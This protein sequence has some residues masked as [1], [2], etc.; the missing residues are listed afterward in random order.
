MRRKGLAATVDILVFTMGRNGSEILLIERKYKPFQGNW[1][2]PGG[3]V[4]ENETFLQAAQREL[5]EETMIANLALNHLGVFD[6]PDRDPRGRTVSVAFWT[7][8]VGKK[9]IKAGSDASRAAW[10]SLDDLPALAFDHDQIIATGQQRIK[11]LY[12]LSAPLFYVPENMKVKQLRNLL[13]SVS[14]ISDC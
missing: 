5:E 8:G 1:A 9:K 13:E 7:I 12:R 6:A 11:D 14:Q 4:E 10:F 3:F 2:L